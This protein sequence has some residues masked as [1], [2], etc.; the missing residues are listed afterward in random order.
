MPTPPDKYIKKGLG[1]VRNPEYDAYMKANAN[2]QHQETPG[3]IVQE[4]EHNDNEELVAEEEALH[5]SEPEHDS[6]GNTV[7]PK[8]IKQRGKMI[9]NPDYVVYHKGKPSLSRSAVRTK[10]DAITEL[11]DLSRDWEYAGPERPMRTL[12]CNPGARWI[13]STFG[14]MKLNRQIKSSRSWGGS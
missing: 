8:Y 3:R 7:P 11:C 6:D 10:L 13:E 2:R 4:K 12:R 1:L 5:T 14:K 9:L